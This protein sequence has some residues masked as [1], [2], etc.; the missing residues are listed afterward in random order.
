MTKDT[1]KQRG[2]E[3]SER[4]ILEIIGDPSNELFGTDRM[5]DALNKDPDAMP[6]HEGK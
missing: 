4:R 5:L 6:E 3:T 1:V 2:S